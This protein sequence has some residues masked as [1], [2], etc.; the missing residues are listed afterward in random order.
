MFTEYA[1]VKELRKVRMQ[2]YKSVELEQPQVCCQTDYSNMTFE[3][4]H[5]QTPHGSQNRKRENASSLSKFKVLALQ[6]QHYSCDLSTAS[7]TH[8][9]TTILEYLLTARQASQTYTQRL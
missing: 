3:Y 4:A 9:P 7:A 5:V 6:P 1:C 8:R 2:A